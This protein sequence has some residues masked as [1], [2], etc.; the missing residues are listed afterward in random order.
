MKK[1]MVVLAA[2]LITLAGLS[3]A[4][5]VAGG[6]P[7]G[8]GGA[9]R[10]LFDPASLSFHGSRSFHG[11]GLHRPLVPFGVPRRH[12]FHP[13]VPFGSSTV[14]V[15]STPSFVVSDSLYDPPAPPAAY[16]TPVVAYPPPVVMPPPPPA[17][18]RVVEYPNGRYELHGDGLTSPYVWV[19]IPKPAPEPPPP[20]PPPD[21]RSTPAPPSR[22]AR[23]ADASSRHPSEL[24]CFADDQGTVTWTD[25]LAKIPERYR[26]RAKRAS[27]IAVSRCGGQG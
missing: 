22:P 21:A 2:S 10:G 25:R 19:W 6:F 27:E 11:P 5:V 20:P 15:F 1:V 13:F 18:P 7:H 14:F 26:S 16:A 24:Y 23:S 8:R 9:Q 12:F 3:P 17:A 4:V